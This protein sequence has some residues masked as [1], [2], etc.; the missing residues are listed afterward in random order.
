MESTPVSKKLFL[1]DSYL[2]ETTAKITLIKQEDDSIG[3][4]LDQ[5]IFHPQGGGQPSDEGTINGLKVTGLIYDREK[6]IIVHKVN[7]NEF[8]ESGLKE[9]DE[10]SLKIDGEKRLLYARLHSAGHF[11]DILLAKLGLNDKLVP[12]KGFHFPDGSYV[13]YTGN[14]DKNEIPVL[15]E[16]LEKL[17]NEEI[18]AVGEDDKA[19][20]K[21]YEYEEGKKL[22]KIPDYIPSD[23]PFR[24]VKLNESDLGCP[25]GGTH[26]KNIKDI[27]SMKIPKI[28]NKGKQVRISY[29]IIKNVLKFV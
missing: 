11:M 4:G 13:E 27:K 8:L 18:Q 20:S 25:C 12:G 15:R 2:Y 1:D 17:A 23:K 26:V 19:I 16:K 3:L 29:T 24:W 14:L 28:I 10:V 5:T 22:F 7:K 9:G 6:D 21:I